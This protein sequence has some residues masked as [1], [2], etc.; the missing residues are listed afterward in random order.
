[1]CSREKK[2]IRGD[3]IYFKKI[4][5]NISSQ[6]IPITLFR[7]ASNL[8][9]LNVGRKEMITCHGNPIRSRMLLHAY[10]H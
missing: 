6:Y 10:A 2:S 3:N 9:R 5:S 8:N 4:T 1:M 7:N